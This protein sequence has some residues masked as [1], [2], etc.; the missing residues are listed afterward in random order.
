MRML[1]ARVYLDDEVVATGGLPPDIADL[2]ARSRLLFVR[3]VRL[4]DMLVGE[5]DSPPTA[6][7]TSDQIP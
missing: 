1:R 7:L 4:D 3:I 5:T 6:A 2:T